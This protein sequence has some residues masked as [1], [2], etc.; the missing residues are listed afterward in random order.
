M[1]NRTSRQPLIFALSLIVLG[2][3]WLLNNLQF[4]PDVN[5][6]LTLALGVF[7]LAIL[8]I[9]GVNKVSVIIGP[10]LLVA[11][12]LSYMRQTGRLDAAYELPALTVL[13]GILILVAHLRFIPQP[14][15]YQPTPAQPKQPE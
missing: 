5:W 8:F 3:G 14:P 7:G 4:A 2:A 1:T 12:V 10:F 11:S 15:W 9:G 13:L 6:V